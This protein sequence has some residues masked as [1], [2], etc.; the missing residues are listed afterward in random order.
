MNSI[1]NKAVEVYGNKQILQTIEEMAELTQALSKYVR[2]KGTD[3]EIKALDN[4]TEEI[5]DVEIMLEQMKILLDI[6]AKDIAFCRIK[7]MNRLAERMN[8]G[9]IIR[10]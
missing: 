4:I 10:K 1:L 6:K 2:N 3:K 7:K 9:F 5:A 8:I